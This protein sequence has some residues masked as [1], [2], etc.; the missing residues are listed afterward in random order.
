MNNDYEQV[1]REYNLPPGVL[2]PE[3]LRMLQHGG[4]QLDDSDGEG[5]DYFPPQD[6]ITQPRL[7]R[8]KPAFEN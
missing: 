2:S 1:L 7:P 5:D 8:M 3:E 6:R 4:I